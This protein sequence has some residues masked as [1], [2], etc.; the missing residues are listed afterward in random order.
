VYTAEIAQLGHGNRATIAKLFME[1]VRRL[2]FLGAVYL[3]LLA[4]VGPWLFTMCLARYGGRVAS[5]LVC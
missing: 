4:L 5:W 2:F 1:T 3:G